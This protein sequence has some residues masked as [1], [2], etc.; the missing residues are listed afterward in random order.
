M[1]I[2]FLVTIV[3]VFGAVALGVGGAD[4]VRADADEL[5]A[6]APASEARLAG[7]TGVLLEN[8]SLDPEQ[9]KIVKQ[10]SGIVPRSPKDMGKLRRKFVRAGYH[11]TDAD[12]DLH[13]RR[14]SCC[15]SIFGLR[16][17]RVPADV[18]G[19]D[20]HDHLGACWAT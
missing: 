12:R 16:A 11:T 18:A 8:Q 14:S 9:S 20:G 4:A 15:R 5:R 17:A 19:L 2:G 6:P 10:L 1:S 7:A 13:A 3:A